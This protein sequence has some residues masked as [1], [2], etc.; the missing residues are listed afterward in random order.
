LTDLLDFVRVARGNQQRSHE[1]QTV[2]GAIVWITGAQS[3]IQTNLSVLP[4][5][6]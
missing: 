1:L 4:H 5:P 3:P 6:E 2:V